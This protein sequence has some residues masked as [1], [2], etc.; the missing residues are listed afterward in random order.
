L[1]DIAAATAIASRR[2]FLMRTRLR[3]LYRV[4]RQRMPPAAAFYRASGFVQWHIAKFRYNAKLGRYRL[5][6]DMV[7]LVSWNQRLSRSD[8][9]AG[10]EIR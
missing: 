7:T 1:R 6:S 2:V 9:N 10:A 8:Q 5:I 3:C 4:S